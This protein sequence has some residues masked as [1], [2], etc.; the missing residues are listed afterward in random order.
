AGASGRVAIGPCCVTRYAGAGADWRY[1]VTGLP[2][3]TYAVEFS[4]GARSSWYNDKSSFMDAD[5]VTLAEGEQRGG[6]DG[7]LIAGTSIAGRV[8][9]DGGAPIA[10]IWVYFNGPH[11]GHVE[12]SAD[13][14]YLISDLPPGD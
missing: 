4:R 3:G 8:T 6:I 11:Y 5:R 10:G 12:T 9:S 13:G 7:T 1:S 2:A 14:T